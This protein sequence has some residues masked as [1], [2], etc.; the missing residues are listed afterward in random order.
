MNEPS[1]RPQSG[2][3]IPPI[4]LAPLQGVTTATFRR[5]LARHFGGFDR[6][7][8]P[9]IPTMTGGR[10]RGRHFRDIL[11]EANR[12]GIP[13]I[14]QLLGRDGDD[15][16]ETANRIRDEFGYDEV[17]WN[18]GCP[19]PTVTARG[20]GAGML[21][22][23]GRVAA[24]LDAACTGLRCRLSIKMRLGMDRDDE[25]L[26]LV[27]C[28]NAHPIAEIT[29]HPRTG[30]QQYEGQADVER[31]ADLK[32]RLMHPVAY[33]GDVGSTEVAVG[34]CTRFGD[35]S[36]LMIG[37]AAI[38]N[39][40]LAAAIRAGRPEPDAWGPDAQARFHDDLYEAYRATLDGGPGP[41]L[42]RMKELWAYWAADFPDIRRVLK[43]RD[44]AGYEA[45][46]ARV[47]GRD[48]A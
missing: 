17:N 18:L 36:S 20:R 41:V 44:F 43:A 24:F 38:A 21:R 2:T 46:V 34:I 10:T 48:G 29:I 27:D 8:A 23:P 16:R 26:A 31:F 25:A 45:A 22:D 14:P 7:M 13:L 37:R 3:R 33:N 35:L 32:A 40:W 19:S 39:P 15:F 30:R 47:F 9:F 6:A 11:P 4:V 28:L 12:G 5:V 42:A 1:Q